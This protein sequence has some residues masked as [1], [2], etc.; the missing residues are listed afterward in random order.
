LRAD[1]SVRL[2]GGQRLAGSALMMHQAISNVMKFA[3]LGLRDAITLATR[4]PARVGRI[5]CRLRGLNT[6]ERA[7]LVRFRFHEAT[8]ELEILETYL[9]GKLVFRKAV[10]GS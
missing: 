10:A 5:A 8:K 4:N 1:G 2:L 9:D 6:A 7:D 3:G